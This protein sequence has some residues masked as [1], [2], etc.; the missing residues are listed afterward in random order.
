MTGSKDLIEI[1]ILGEWFWIYKQLLACNAKV[2]PEFLGGPVRPRIDYRHARHRNPFGELSGKQGM[3]LVISS[4]ERISDQNYV[5]RM[6]NGLLSC[7]PE[8]SKERAEQ[9]VCLCL[10]RGDNYRH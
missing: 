3:T 8:S 9:L 5:L 7:R 6:D 2:Q 1:E 10:R 4:R